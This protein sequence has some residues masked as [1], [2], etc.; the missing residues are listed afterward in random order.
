MCNTRLIRNPISTGIPENP[1]ITRLAIYMN[2]K[3]WAYPDYI[4]YEMTDVAYLPLFCSMLS[5]RLELRRRSKWS[6]GN[7][8]R[9]F[10]SGWK[11]NMAFVWDVHFYMHI[12]LFML[13]YA[14]DCHPHVLSY[15]AVCFEYTEKKNSSTRWVSCC[16][17]L[18]KINTYMMSGHLWGES[19][20]DHRLPAQRVSESGLW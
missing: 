5:R 9:S 2:D 11:I 1:N 16:I 15:C 12:K 10:A 3:V 14:V 20:S 19:T 17:S 8:W 13:H 18:I 7:F 6:I 4:N